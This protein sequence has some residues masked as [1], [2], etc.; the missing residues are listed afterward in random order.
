MGATSINIGAFQSVEPVL[1][2]GSGNNRALLL[3]II[4][5]VFGHDNEFLVYDNSLGHS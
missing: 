2:F 1:G 4:L 5:T 3:T